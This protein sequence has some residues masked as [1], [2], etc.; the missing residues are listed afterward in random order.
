MGQTIGLIG[1]VIIGQA[2]V[3]PISSVP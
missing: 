2:A 1:G 3:K